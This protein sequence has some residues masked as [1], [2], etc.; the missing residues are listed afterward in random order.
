MIQHKPDNKY[1]NWDMDKV[2]HDEWQQLIWQI[3]YEELVDYYKHNS[4]QLHV[5]NK[6]VEECSQ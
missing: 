6:M 4:A 5:I 3:P 2:D 1:F